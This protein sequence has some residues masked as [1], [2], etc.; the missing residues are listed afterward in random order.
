MEKNARYT[1]RV[2]DGVRDKFMLYCKMMNVSPSDVLTDVM[3]DFN[4][5]V[6]DIMKMKD[7]GELQSMIQSKFTQVQREID[8]L[9][10]KRK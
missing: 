10:A 5:N 1:F 4:N 7:I 3:V 9:K 6:D 8:T 2:N